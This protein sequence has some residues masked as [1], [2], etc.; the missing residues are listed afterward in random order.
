MPCLGVD[1]IEIERIEKAVSRWSERFLRRVY[2]AGE[3]E[4]CQRRV[5]ALAARFAAKEAVMKLLG[6]GVKGTGWKEIEVLSLQSGK[7][8]LHLHGRALKRAMEM[9]I[10]NIEIS[11]SHS[12]QN[13]LAT[14]LG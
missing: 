3:L 1:L 4:I 13:A 12:H 10:T 6:T 9:G 14:A 8:V 5:S 2:T 7:P 11:M